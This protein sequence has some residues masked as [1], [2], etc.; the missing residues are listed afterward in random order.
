[1]L[2]RQPVALA[3]VGGA[4]DFERLRRHRLFGAADHSGYLRRTESQL[5]RL[6]GSGVDV[7]LR[8][9]DAVEYEDFCA[10]RLLDPGDPVARVAYAADP[11]F[12]GE[13]FRYEGQ[14]LA[15]LLPALADEHRLRLRIAAGCAALLAALEGAGQPEQRL[16]ALV[17]YAAAVYLAVAA[18]AG[19]GRHR[20]VLRPAGPGEAEAVAEVRWQTVAG[21]HS[22]PGREAEAF[23]LALAAALVSGRPGELLLHPAGSGAV[24]GWVLSAAGLR[25]MAATG[26]RARPGFPLPEQPEAGPIPG[27]GS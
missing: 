18:G 21:R 8:M 7:H 14:R 20:L 26:A 1:V 12:L 15:A 19:E 27:R 11:E 9:F 2:L 13:P 22:A 10:E 24:C 4:A 16:G 6:R 25:P 17:E 5:R 3:V 23:C